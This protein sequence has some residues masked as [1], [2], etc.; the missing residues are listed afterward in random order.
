MSRFFENQWESIGPGAILLSPLGGLYALGWWG[1]QTTYSLGIKKPFES[2]SKVIV[3]GN[4]MAGGTGKS[5]TT[6]FIARALSSIGRKVVIGCSGYGSEHEQRATI[7]PPGELRASVWG[8]EPAM[9]RFSEPNLPLVVGRDRVLAAQLVD[10][11]F[12][13]HILLMDDGFQHLRLKNHL[14]IILDPPSRNTLCIPAGP[15]R[16]PNSTGR[17]R[18]DLV[19]PSSSFEIKQIPIPIWHV[20]GIENKT[21]Q[22]DLLC[23]IARPERLISS[24]TTQGVSLM[25]ITTLPDHAKLHEGNLNALDESQNSTI[26]TVKDWV[27]IKER[28]DLENKSIYVADYRVEISPVAEFTNWLTERLHGITL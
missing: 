14:S 24:L 5:P 4:L 23:A 15:Y 25:K 17:R 2:R 1:Y 28:T 10:Q 18:A 13:D 8:D 9:I 20:H 11:A 3:I 12:D 6:I 19:L 22:F 27:K 21:E 16:E 7:A 26:V